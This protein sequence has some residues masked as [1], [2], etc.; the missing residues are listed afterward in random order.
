MDAE[1]FLQLHRGGCVLLPNAWDA[2]SARVLRAAGFEA[3][4]TT[5]AGVAFSLGRPDHAAAGRVPQDEP[6]ELFGQGQR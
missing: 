6:N 4:A 2:G 5:S 3:I 1:G